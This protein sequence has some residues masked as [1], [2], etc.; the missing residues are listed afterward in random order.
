MC[1]RDSIALDIVEESYVSRAKAEGYKVFVYTV[2]N[3]EDMLLLQQW[4][5]DGIFSNVPD[6][7]CETLNATQLMC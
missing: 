2:D 1:I 3:P 5:V 7:A 6:L 4:G